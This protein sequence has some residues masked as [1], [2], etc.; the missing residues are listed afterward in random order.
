MAENEFVGG[1]QSKVPNA[2]IVLLLGIFSIVGCLFGG[3]PGLIIAAIGLFLA[4]KGKSA[5]NAAPDSFLASSYSNLKLGRTLCWVGLI[6]SA[7]VLLM[8]MGFYSF[9]G[10][11]GMAAIKECQEN[12][13]DMA[14][15]QE[16]IMEILMSLSEE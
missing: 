1:M 9:M 15:Q 3:W 16:C 6:L 7:I 13:S 2:L 4:S 12:S 8:M 14:E 11:E 5:F 10:E